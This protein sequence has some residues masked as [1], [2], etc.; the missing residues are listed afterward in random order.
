M[1]SG[2][3]SDGA[4]EEVGRCFVVTQLVNPRLQ[5]EPVEREHQDKADGCGVGDEPP[6]NSNVEQALERRQHGP[7]PE[8]E[9]GRAHCPQDGRKGGPHVEEP[10][11]AK[12][13]RS[14]EARSG[15]REQRQRR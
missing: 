9:G 3:R 7:K 2:Q 6:R 15:S 13:S 8:S 12:R 5:G 11:P 1:K 14:G 4:Q 10:E